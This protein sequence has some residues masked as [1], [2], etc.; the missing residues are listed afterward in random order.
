MPQKF[1]L[2]TKDLVVRLMEDRILAE[3]V[4]NQEACKI[5]A[6]KLGLSWYTPTMGADSTP[7]SMRQ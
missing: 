6:P 5:A 4:S 7:R 1:D 3:N 2:D